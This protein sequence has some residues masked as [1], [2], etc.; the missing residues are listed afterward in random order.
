MDKLTNNFKEILF[1]GWVSVY[2]L[3]FIDVVYYFVVIAIFVSVVS[4]FTIMLIEEYCDVDLDAD[5]F[6]D[7]NSL[8]ALIIASPAI[9]GTILHIITAHHLPIINIIHG[10]FVVW[11]VYFVLFLGIFSLSQKG[12]I[13]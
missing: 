9:C 1:M 13:L 8:Y 4:L 7:S 3:I 12:R 5:W 6:P 2:S 10:L 11:T